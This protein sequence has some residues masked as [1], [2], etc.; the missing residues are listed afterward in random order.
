MTAWGLTNEGRR[1]LQGM[2]GR[3]SGDRGVQSM[4]C[5]SGF[6]SRRR[7]QRW[8][9]GGQLPGLQCRGRTRCIA[10][11]KTL[12]IIILCGHSKLSILV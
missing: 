10:L 8:V 4:Q 9:Y 3:C 11:C 1:E 2:Q 5:S 7:V 6:A 12:N